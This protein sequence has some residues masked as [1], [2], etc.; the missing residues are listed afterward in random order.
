LPPA[1]GRTAVPAPQSSPPAAA[2][3]A[4]C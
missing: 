2:G 3:R 4:L 1:P